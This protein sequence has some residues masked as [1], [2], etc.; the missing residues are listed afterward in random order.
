MSKPLILAIDQ[1]TT[2]TRALIFN[3]EGQIVA[4]AQKELPLITPQSGWVEQDANQIWHDVVETCRQA[5][6][7]I[8]IN[9]VVGIG[10]TNQRETTILWNKHTGEPIYNAIVWQDRRTAD[11]CETLKPYEGDIQ[12][13]TGLLADPYFS[14]TKIRWLLDNH[15]GDE[16]DILCGTIDCFLLWKLTEGKVHAT[17]ASNAARTMLYNIHDHQWDQDQC[18]MM[19]IP[20]EILPNVMDNCADFGVTEIFDRPL[21]ILAMV[22]DQQAATFGQ[23]CF[24]RGQVKSTYGTGCFALMDTGDTCV[25]SRNRLL[26]TIAWSIDGQV[27][28]ALEGSIFVAGAAVQFLRDALKFFDKAPESEALAQ[29]VEDTDGVVFVP[30]FTGLGAPYWDPHARGAIMG[31]SRGTTQ[32]HITRAVLEAQAFQTRDLITAMQDD[33][34][35]TITTIRVD[36]GLVANDFV[37]QALANQTNAVIDRP[38]NQEATVWGAAA[39]AFLQAGVFQSLDDVA[40]VYHIDRCFESTGNADDHNRLY[41]RW[42]DAI[43]STRMF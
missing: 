5:L 1:G 23:A 30:A 31:L 4:K 14:A 41:A 2:S 28:Y 32:A 29:S 36:G 21:P 13:R 40:R 27:T 8:S 26:S 11:F 10:I 17:D 35:V 19:G 16:S 37:C 18:D 12:A 33:T 22:G 42:Q 20:M 25:T 3:A 15:Q 9:D 39:M 6:S 43:K 34:D 38:V 7:H 24:E